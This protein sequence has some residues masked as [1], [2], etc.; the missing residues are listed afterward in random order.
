MIHKKILLPVFLIIIQANLFAQNESIFNFPK[1]VPKP[2]WVDKINWE[3]A[4]FYQILETI[5]ACESGE[6]K[7]NTSVEKEDPYENALRR[8]LNSSRVFIQSNGDILIDNNKSVENFNNL[9]KN[10][11]TFLQKKEDIKVAS[12]QRT[13]ISNG[14]AKWT[15]L[16]PV[17]TYENGIKKSWQA[18]IFSIVISPSNPKTIY[19]GSET[20]IIFKSIDKGLNWVSISDALPRDAVTA[21]AVS[22]DSESTLFAS[23]GNTP[24][25][26]KSNDGGATWTSLVFPGG[27]TNK[28]IINPTNGR[29]LTAS[30][31]GIYYSDNSGTSWIKATT[32]IQPGTEIFDVAINPANPS[33]VY[34]VSAINT[35]T[36]DDMVVYV[37]TNGGQSFTSSPL[38][39]NTF[40][41]GARFGTSIS[42]PNY[43]Y[44][45]TLQNDFPKL[46]MSSNAGTNWSTKT[47]FVGTALGGSNAVNGMSNGQGFYDLDIVVSPNNINHIIVGTTTAYKSIDGGLNFN[48][49]GGYAGNFAIHPDIQCMIAMGNDTYISTDGGVNYSPDFFSSTS[50]FEP[51]NY[52]LTASDNWG[53]GQGWSEDIVVGGRYHNGNAAL[54]EQYGLGN[55]VQLGGAEDATGHVFE[56]PGERGISGFRDLGSTLKKIPSSIN[57]KSSDSKYI[58]KK[59]PSD[60]F[61][62]QFSSKLMQDPNFANIFYVGNG[63]SLWK[64]ENYGLS[65]IELKNFGANVW[66]FDIAR[67]NPNIFYLCTQLG[68]FKSTDRGNSWIQLSLPVGVIYQYYNT[69]ITVN[70]ANENEVWFCMAKGSASNKVFKS[71]DGGSSWS[72]YTGSLLNNKSIAF[73]IS[74]GGTNSGVY[75]ISNSN[76]TRVYY[77]DA[78]M[79]EWVDF[80]GDLP[81]N[82]IARS[83]GIIFYRDNKLRLTGNRGTWESAL[84]TQSTPLA[85]PLANKQF[86]AC[87]KD[88]ITFRD[89]SIL[90]YTGATWQWSFPGANYVSSNSTREVKVTYPQIGN[91]S[92]TLTVKDSKGN[93]NTRKVD[94]LIKFTTN[95]CETDSLPGKSLK[96]NFD[97]NYY[98]IGSA[99]INSN[100]FTISCWFKPDGFQKSFSQLISHDPYPGSSYGFGLG[101]SFKGYTP[102]LNLCYTDNL[103]GFGNSTSAIADSSKWNHAALVYSPSGVTVYLNGVAFAARSS[104]MP[105]VNLSTSPFYINKDI[106]NQGGDYKGEIDEIKIYNY[107]LNQNEIREKMHIINSNIPSESGLLKYVQFNNF[108]TLSNNTYELVNKNSISLPSQ[109]VLVKSS[110]PI[111]K[112]ISV[113]KNISN[114]GRHIFSGTGVDLYVSSKTGSVLPNGEV[115][116]SKINPNPSFLPDSSN[117]SYFGHYY[118][119]NNY[120]SNTTFSSLDSIWFSNLNFSS[121]NNLANA[122]SLHKRSSFAYGRDNWATIG[123]GINISK[124][125]NSALTF[126]GSGISS[127]G[128]MIISAPIICNPIESIIKTTDSA[129]C[130]DKKV[131]LSLNE[132]YDSTL[133][134]IKWYSSTSLNGSYTKTSKD[135]NALI[136]DNLRSTTYYKSQI[137]CKND[138]QISFTTKIIEIKVTQLPL[139][140]TVTNLTLCI[141]ANN[142]SLQATALSGN[143]LRWYGTNESGGTPSSSPPILSSYNTGGI[144]FYVSQVDNRGCE[145]NRAAIKY[146]VNQLPIKP[147]ISWSG[148]ELSIPPSYSSYQW[149]LNDVNILGATNNLYKPNSSGNYR[150]KVTN[151]ENCVDTSNQYNLIVTSVGNLSINGEKINVYPNPFQNILVI[152]VGRR[153]NKPILIRLYNTN[154]SLNGKWEL[155]QKTEEINLSHLT[156]GTYILE[157]NS[158]KNKAIITIIK[159]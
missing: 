46:L 134:N 113:R 92:V 129:V 155:K 51:R 43:V 67:S 18:N 86:I 132:N 65:Y 103:V 8:W 28:I 99:N 1:S 23:M 81:N 52:G 111:G 40:C 9:L 56:I 10:Q 80:S 127:F 90:D 11:I 2:C 137:F 154:G 68:L 77:R 64:S 54:Y 74:Q 83:G 112:G 115:V 53:F 89:F 105:V 48:P 59:W 97:K 96:L 135:S 17:L 32:S 30:E 25:M 101:F 156:S 47:T 78:S 109:N 88:T 66:R 39:A 91:Y 16:G 42:N 125:T 19:C 84:Y 138:P 145:S 61:Y 22:P 41:T 107:A 98:S 45:I 140:P 15:P 13:S 159:K 117:A 26:I 119:I 110:A 141:G 157:L 131:T 82:F 106:H 33:I 44:C 38:P 124:G 102:N 133:F 49:L 104:T 126:S 24:A 63:K 20:G 29:I 100:T 153:P 14:I 70:P 95:Q 57:E 5:Q 144:N 27:F 4:N 72:N 36:T 7:D 122:Y 158:E 75:A 50:T 62:G 150:V 3:K 85:M 108:D 79:N 118:I 130:Y 148:N 6:K 146:T 55:A 12:V 73:I 152:D 142:P 128:Q 31:K 151:A 94:N 143:S 123:N 93:T 60:D 37:S 87:S 121:A 139:P 21:I 136:T 147:T 76:I 116:V 114:G 71:I 69:D 35:S 120:G 149:L 34:A 58:N